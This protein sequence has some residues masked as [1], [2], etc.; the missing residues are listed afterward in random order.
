MHE[1]RLRTI[2]PPF[3]AATLRAVTQIVDRA[4]RCAA[5]IPGRADDYEGGKLSASNTR[6]S[7]QEQEREPEQHQRPII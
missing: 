7:R 2:E 6:I 5:G 3:L 1:G 4:A